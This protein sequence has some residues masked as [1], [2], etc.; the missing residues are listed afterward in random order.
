MSLEE[1][2][3]VDAST[4]PIGKLITI[5]ARGQTLYLNHTLVGL[6]INATQLHFLFEIYHQN[7]MNQENIAER[8]NINKGAVARSIKKLEDNGLVIR[9]IDENNRRQ[10][11]VSLTDK[12]KKTLKE[13]ISILKIW[14]DE[15][16]KGNAIE[17]TVLQQALKEIA[18]KTIELNQEGCNGKKEQKH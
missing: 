3:T 17:K 12:G 6:G 15:V 10:N 5:I 18:I 9:E 16:F 2:K 4:L 1:F 11:R 14:E 8:C 13:S 7:N